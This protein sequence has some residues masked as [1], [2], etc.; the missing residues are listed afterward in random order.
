MLD[1]YAV[2]A[3]NGLLLGGVYL[4][5]ASGL[6]LIFGVM[7]IVNLAHGDFVVVGGLLAFS[8]YEMIQFNPLLIGIPAA[9]ILLGLIG[10]LFQWGV[11]KRLKV[12]GSSGELRTL[13]AT[14][15]LSYVVGNAA[16]LIWGSRFQS[17]PLLQMGV[18]LGVGY[19][20]LALIVTAAIAFVIGIIVALW[21]SKTELGS[22]VRATSQ[23]ELGASS[24][25]INVAGIRLLTFALGSAMAG[26]AGV[27]LIVVQP[28]QSA[29]SGLALTVLAFAVIALGGL[30]NYFGA[31]I[32]A[33]II[34]LIS[35][36]ASY[37]LGSDA[38]V[39][40]IYILFIAT[41]ILRPQGLLGKSV[42]V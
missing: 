4:L 8:I 2:L 30:G 23:S 17:L 21:L 16:F 24:S 10:G 13:L 31:F 1:T 36:A 9:A 25:G 41:L 29:T 28:L 15:G 37:F 32:A 35:T 3:I 40:S 5:M 20:R 27:L 6:N 7:K 39:A 34:G 14:F 12:E 26:V 22:A 33:E 11:I 18:N 19:V 38:G 42:R